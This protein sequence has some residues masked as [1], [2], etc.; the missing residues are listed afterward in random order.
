MEMSKDLANRLREVL[1]DGHW[2][3]HTNFKEQLTSTNWKEAVEKV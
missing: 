1:L 3:A 2:I